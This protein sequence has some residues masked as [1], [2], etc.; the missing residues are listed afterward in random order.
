MRFVH[1]ERLPDRESARAVERTAIQ[2]ESPLHNV[3]DRP[4]WNPSGEARKLARARRDALARESIGPWVTATEV[5]ARLKDFVNEVS[6]GGPPVTITHDK[7]VAA[8]VSPQDWKLLMEIRR[9]GQ[10]EISD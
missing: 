7:P 10:P 9:R 1:V 8:L 6:F 3:A 5:R 4:G 2:T